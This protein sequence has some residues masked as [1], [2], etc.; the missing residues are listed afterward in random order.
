M[1]LP[2]PQGTMTDIDGKYSINVPAESKSLTFSFIGMQLQEISVG[3]KTQIDV[4]MVESAIG[5]NEVVVIG[6][7]SMKKSDL[8]GSVSQANTQKLESV[9]VYNISEALKGQSSGVQVKNNSGAPGSRIEVRIRGGNSMIGSNDPLYVVDGF[10]LTG[11]IELLNPSDIASISVLKDA[12]ATAIYGS[13]GAN[14]VVIITSKRGIVGQKGL[15]SINSYFGQQ[16]V[17]NRYK[18]LNPKQYAVVANEWM[19]NSGLAPYF[20]VDNVSN[21]GTDWQD[22]IFRVAPIQNHT[23]TFSGSSE[24]TR[25]SLS[26]NYYKQDGVVINS[27]IQRGSFRLNLDHDIKSWLSISENL[28]MSRSEQFTVPVD[29]G[30]RGNT[31]L[32]GALSARPHCQ[33]MMPMVNIHE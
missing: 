6:Y 9:P 20:N 14:G 13:R 15:I 12:S 23:I 11:G 33:F 32:S 10:P 18:V 26:G 1:L 16:E 28:I 17:A 30:S 3:T 21:P 22:V 19:K 5:L 31:V 2:E 25:Y 8:T 29:N 4:T 24:K 27:G 7:G